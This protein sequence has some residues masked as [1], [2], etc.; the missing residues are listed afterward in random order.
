MTHWSLRS[1]A[2]AAVEEELVDDISHAAVSGILRQADLQLHGFR[3][4]KTTIWDEEAVERALKILWYYERI[5]SL[6]QK[7]EV[8]LAVDEKPNLQVLE[9]AAPKQP[10]RPGQMERQEFEFTRSLSN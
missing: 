3:W 4:W 1:L 2:Q 9:R 8:L 5:E 7:R 6:W 10:M